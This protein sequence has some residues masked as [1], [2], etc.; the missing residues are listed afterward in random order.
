MI[1]LP[2]HEGQPQWS[3]CGGTWATTPVMLNPIRGWSNAC[4]KKSWRI[5]GCNKPTRT[6]V[7]KDLADT[8]QYVTGIR[9]LVEKYKLH[10]YEQELAKLRTQLAAHDEWVR[11][12]VLPSATT[13]FQLPPA[14]YAVQ[15]ENYGV[16][17]TP[18]ELI[19]I[20]HE[21]FSN[22]QSQ[23]QILAVK[24]AEAQHLQS[25][26]YRDVIRDLKKEQL[27]GDAI[28]PHYQ[29]RLAEIEEILR[30]QHLVTLPERAA[31]IRLATAAETVQQ[32]APH[33]VP[34]P[35]LNNKGER[36]QFV[37]PMGTGGSGGKQ[38]KYDDL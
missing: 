5:K 21:G 9:L 11:K 2:V 28:L 24:V 34:P 14:L 6:E 22:I 17:Y 35:F 13:D 3:D 37:L 7:E 18:D 1:K 10:G 33:M 30:Q 4:I 16:D 8:G 38:L 15:L 25:T 32:P 36:G 23:M 12:R 27:T 31:I 29:K 20:G 26:D 19:S